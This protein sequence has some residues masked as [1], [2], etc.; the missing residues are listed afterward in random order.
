MTPN[1]KSKLRAFLRVDQ[2]LHRR[3]MSYIAILVSGWQSEWRVLTTTV[4]MSGFYIY[5]FFSQIS[6]YFQQG[7]HF[8]YYSKWHYYCFSPP[9]RMWEMRKKKD[10]VEPITQVHLHLGV[11]L[12]TLLLGILQVTIKVFYWSSN[13]NNEFWIYGVPVLRKA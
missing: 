1:R 12:E 7:Y 4:L 2:V 10:V 8:Y 3:K 13:C 5:I 11:S 9:T 6:L